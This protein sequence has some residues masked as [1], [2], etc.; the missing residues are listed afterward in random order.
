MLKF[1][2]YM[3]FATAKAA[4]I[5]ND[6]FNNV[7]LKYGLTRSQCIAMYYINSAGSTNQKDL[8]KQMNIR[9]STMTGLLDRME[10]DGLIERKP[11]KEDM[12]RK[13]ISLS[14][15]GVEELDNISHV[16]DEFIKEATDKIDDESIGIFNKVLDKMVESVLEWQDNKIKSIE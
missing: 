16:S 5:M 9:E 10:R 13:S 15:K 4:K 14:K 6:A 2:E 11:D 8:A 1:E 12:R 7:V 3:P